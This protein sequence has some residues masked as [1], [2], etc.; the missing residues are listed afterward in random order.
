MSDAHRP[1]SRLARRR[2]A[3]AA[4]TFGRHAEVHEEVGNRLL[5]RLDG[6]R[7]EPQRMLIAGVG[8]SHELRAARRRFPKADL[9]ALG[10]VLGLLRAARARRGL[11]GV[12]RGGVSKVIGELEGMP[13]ASGAVDGVIS[14][15]ILGWAGDLERAV[16]E[17]ARVLRPEGL[18]L[19]STLG[20]DTLGE[21]RRAWYGA[22]GGDHARVHGFIDLHD[23]GDALVRAGFLDPV[24]EAERLTVTYSSVEA[25]HAELRGLGAT[26]VAAGRPRGLTSP[27]RAH[28]ARALYAREAD[29]DGRIPVTLELTVGH[30]WMGQ[31]SR[32]SARDGVATIPLTRIG[33]RRRTLSR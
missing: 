22:D 12:V 16:T 33:G 11:R 4:G 25:L 30:A 3:A 23:V 15:L 24:M 21:L 26:N 19:F 31:A 27:G 10:P 32:A 28:A 14:N 6:L 9:Y 17:C 20:P 2:L 18:L 7:F 8:T 29:A 5:E 1:D 13:L